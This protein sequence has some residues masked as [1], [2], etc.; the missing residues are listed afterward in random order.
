MR[1]RNVPSGPVFGRYGLYS[2]LA[3]VHCLREL[4]GELS[5]F[6]QFEETIDM[7]FDRL[8][9]LLELWNTPSSHVRGPPLWQDDFLVRCRREFNNACWQ[10]R[11]FQLHMH[12]IYVD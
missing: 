8:R 4:V 1:V 7:V 3:N 10:T 2:T 9:R 12:S 11:V 5:K 6:M